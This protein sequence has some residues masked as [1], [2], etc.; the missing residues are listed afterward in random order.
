MYNVIV[1]DEKQEQEQDEEEDACLPPRLRRT[2]DSSAHAHQ[3]PACCRSRGYPWLPSDAHNA[4][5][6]ADEGQTK[7]SLA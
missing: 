1:T 4:D 2:I 3:Q 6:C 7:D 5:T